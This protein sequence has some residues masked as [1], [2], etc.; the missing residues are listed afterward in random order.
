MKMKL[1]TVTML[2][3]MSCLSST[4]QALVYNQG[5]TL[6]IS[7]ATLP[8]LGEA[9]FPDTTVIAFPATPWTV[10]C[11][12]LF[13]CTFAPEYYL[14]KLDI[15]EDRVDSIPFYTGVYNSSY[16]GLFIPRSINISNPSLGGLLWEDLE[17]RMELTVLSGP[18]TLDAFDISVFSGDRVWGATFNTTPVPEPST[19]LLLGAGLIGLAG[20]RLRSRGC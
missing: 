15:Y 7:F 10:N 18:A 2:I 8:Y 20:L 13:N 1:L 14:F 17:G 5:D 3:I 4:A 12:P 9:D 19:V 11:D 16:A 6:T